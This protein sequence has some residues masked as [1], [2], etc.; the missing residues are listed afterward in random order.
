MAVKYLGD[1]A[2][3]GTCLGRSATDLIAFYGATPIVRPTVS[4]TA[5]TTA[6]ITTTTNN[7]GFANTTQGTDLCA[8]VGEIRTALTNLGLVT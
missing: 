3:D 4:D 6:L 2:P 7:Y 8:I 5:I 1:A